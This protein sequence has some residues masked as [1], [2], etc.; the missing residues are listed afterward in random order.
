VPSQ[1]LVLLNGDFL[2]EQAA[3]FAERVAREVA[4]GAAAGGAAAGGAA[5]GASAPGALVDRAWRLALARAPTPAEH[6]LALAYLESAG[7][8]LDERKP[9]LAFR[10]AMPQRVES[11]FLALLSGSDILHAPPGWES[12]RGV[13]GDGYN[14]TY[15][16]DPG[17]GPVAFA[18]GP[19]VSDFTLL[20]RVRLPEAEGV[21]GLVLRGTPQ[22]DDVESLELLLDRQAG[23]ARLVHH[24]AD[25]I[26]VLAETPASLPAETW[27]DVRVEARGESLSASVRVPA[28]AAV[29]AAADASAGA[30]GAV[31][32]AAGRQDVRLEA[33]AP[34]L[35]P[36]GRPGVRAAGDTLR[37]A[38]LTIT[39]PTGTHT[40]RAADP[41]PAR[42]A[43]ESLC[44]M[45]FNLNE[46]AYVD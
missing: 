42:R 29:G 14:K 15:A 3:A 5:V 45:L 38:S 36:E 41:G 17:R 28:G 9:D 1:A 31:E 11:D 19:A 20:A 44:L 8:A 39:T 4:G 16:L 18:P 6:A 40:L 2:N 13:W 24:H 46:F 32:G 7:R 26:D 23:V 21:A 35:V 30:A 25:A 27:F 37:I 10:L 33:R 43:L 34:G 12:T 22:G